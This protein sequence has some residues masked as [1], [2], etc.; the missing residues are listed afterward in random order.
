MGVC[1]KAP[2]ERRFS[3]LKV[4]GVAVIGESIRRFFMDENF[5]DS[6]DEQMERMGVWII[7]P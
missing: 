6:K 5:G 4:G 1:I 7:L 2:A 3:A